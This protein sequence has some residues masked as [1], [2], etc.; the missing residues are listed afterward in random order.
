MPRP[1]RCRV[2]VRGSLPADWAEWFVGMTATL[3]AD[4]HTALEGEL[5]DQASLH[6]VTSRVRDLGLELVSLST[7]PTD[8]TQPTEPIDT[9]EG[10]TS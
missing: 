10:P 9:T 7:E 1:F 6:G 4:G 5:P 8:P 2:V 3:T